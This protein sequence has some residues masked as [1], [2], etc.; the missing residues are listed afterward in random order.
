M[1][2][3][4]AFRM[5]PELLKKI[6]E[7]G[8]E[9][10]LD[11]STVIRKLLHVGYAEIRKERSAKLYMEGKITF[12]EA[13]HR[14]GLTLWDMEHYLVD[15]GFRSEYSVEDLEREIKLLS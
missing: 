3:V 5:E 10:V 15:K 14:A 4:V 6:N 8:K 13:A 7:L 12:T 9:E 11:R 2:E 1:P